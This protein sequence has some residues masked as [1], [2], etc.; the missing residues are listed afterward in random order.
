MKLQ[1]MYFKR[2]SAGY[3]HAFNSHQSQGKINKLLVKKSV[4]SSRC[5]EFCFPKIA[6]NCKTKKNKN[7]ISTQFI[8]NIFRLV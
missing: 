1:S 8:L 6:F 4:P 2:I 5:V 3:S 7:E